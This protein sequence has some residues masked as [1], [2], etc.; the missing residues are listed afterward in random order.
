MVGLNG[1]EQR[2]ISS[3]SGGQKQRLAIAV[4]LAMHAEIL[5]LDEPIAAID[6]EGAIEIYRLLKEI[7]KTYHTTIL[8]AEHDLKYVADFAD[9]LIV[10]DAGEMKFAGSVNDCLN[11]MHQE[12]I[13]PEAIPL[14][15]KIYLEM[16]DTV[17]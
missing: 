10:M 2:N 13:Y 8:V 15:W 12:K 17:C 7:N 1:L 6:P 9:Q 11:Y 3:L 14:R 5:I 16:G 4:M